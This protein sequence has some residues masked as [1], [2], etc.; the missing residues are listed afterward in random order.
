M[1]VCLVEDDVRL[2]SL[3]TQALEENRHS[4]V[5]LESGDQA[6]AYINAH[7]FDLVLLDLMLP[8]VSGWSIL[9]Q[10]RQSNCQLPVIVLSARDTVPEM[11]R[12]L[13]L[14]ADDYLT[15]PFHFEMFLARLRSVSRRGSV[16]QSS[17]LVVGPIALHQGECSVRLDGGRVDLTRRE[18]M[19]LE[20]LM[21]RPNQVLTRDQLADAVWGLAAEVSKNN[22]EVH[23]HSLRAKL[24]PV[25]GSMIQTVRGIGYVLQRGASAA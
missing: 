21:R 24:G 17:E 6:A 9:K 3:V 20:T 14:G 13:D 10:L 23:M 4:V 22:L 15:K 18:Y 7:P 5:H 12:A 1:Q 2:A 19:L 25:C 11:V 16:P 8:G